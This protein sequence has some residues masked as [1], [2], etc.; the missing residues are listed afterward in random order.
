MHQTVLVVDDEAAIRVTLSAILE[1]NGFQVQTASCAVDAIRSIG[2]ASF[3]LVMT[4]LKME[5]DRAGFDVA[6]FAAK[7]NPTPVVVVISGYPTLGA[8]WKRRG[9][10]AFFV[11]PTDTSL[12]LRSIN[13][14]LARRNGAAAA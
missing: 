2:S 1:A 10:H 5:T 4:D 3:D 14:L 8:D 9:V 7:Q 11:K 6:E 13:E 12:M